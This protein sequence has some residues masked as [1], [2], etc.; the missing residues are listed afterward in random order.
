MATSRAAVLE[1]V[2]RMSVRSF[3]VPEIGP[4]EALLRVE[5]AGVC[6][7]D[8]KYYHGKLIAPL[9]IILG[10]E[11]LGRIAAIGERART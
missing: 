7:T 11:I 8:Y 4:D 5:M 6:G 3:E 2:E 1:D 9:P 10:H